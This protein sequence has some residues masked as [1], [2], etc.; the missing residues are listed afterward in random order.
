MVLDADWISIMGRRLALNQPP[1]TRCH[2]IWN[3]LNI[4]TP[5]PSSRLPTTTPYIITPADA[6]QPTCT[7]S[8]T[9]RTAIS[10]LILAPPTTIPCHIVKAV[11]PLDGG[12]KAIIS[13]LAATSQRLAAI[14][15]IRLNIRP[16]QRL[17]SYSVR[18]HPPH[19]SGL[20]APKLMQHTH[21]FWKKHIII[22]LGMI[23]QSC[24]WVIAHRPRGEW[25]ICRWGMTILERQH[26]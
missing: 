9:R 24:G 21:F 14:S 16:G 1:I 11:Q 19:S 7:H 12:Q 3:S 13:L 10:G 25:W 15:Y 8:V 18:L 20:A 23:C 6:S 17:N 4:T 22:A 2:Q 5:S 26:S